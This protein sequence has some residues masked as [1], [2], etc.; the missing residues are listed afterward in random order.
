MSNVKK[1]L[2]LANS[3]VI[4]TNKARQDIKDE[5]RSEEWER[6]QYNDLLNKTK[7]S[8]EK[9]AQ[10]MIEVAKGESLDARNKAKEA[11]VKPN[12]NVRQA[13]SAAKVYY[14]NNARM[15]FDGLEPE[16]AIKVYPRIIDGL[17][18]QERK[19]HL[20][21][22]EDVLM[23]KMKDDGYRASAEMEI[24]KHK[25]WDEKEAIVLAQR[26]EKQLEKVESIAEHFK[27]DIEKI[28]SGQLDNPGY[29]YTTLLDEPTHQEQEGMEAFEEAMKP[30][31]TPYD[32]GSNDHPDLQ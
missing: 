17:T 26:A 7:D 5:G 13:D 6:K 10:N 25:A 20:H 30:T 23:S 11:R 4:G 3:M 31:G 9:I 24:F 29:D 15:A 19:E 8:S 12:N 1:F 2:S 28:A 21:V 14:Q 16:E 22:F 32:G 27:Y 18:E